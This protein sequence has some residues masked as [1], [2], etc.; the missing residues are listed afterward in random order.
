MFSKDFSQMTNT[1]VLNTLKLLQRY[2]FQSSNIV[3]DPEN[4][5][6]V[7]KINNILPWVIVLFIPDDIL[8]NLQKSKTV[9][10]CCTTK[11]L[12]N[13]L[14][15]LFFV[16]FSGNNNNF[17]QKYQTCF[18]C[19]YQVKKKL[20]TIEN[21]SKVISYYFFFKLL[22]FSF[23]VTFTVDWK[24]KKVRK[25]VT[26]S[27]KHQKSKNVV[28]SIWRKNF[29]EEKTQKSVFQVK[30][31]VS[32]CVSQDLRN[33]PTEKMQTRNLNPQMKTIYSQQYEVKFAYHFSPQNTVQRRLEE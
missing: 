11:Y 17:P 31:L 22:P 7:F 29:L 13:R 32:E 4:T 19:C 23:N 12:K 6:K 27:K 18:F 25:K 2:F 5:K 33:L 15:S 26:L 30:L 24:L 8:N 1:T 14:T 20:K 28:N 21:S 16:F 9:V 3:F 10:F